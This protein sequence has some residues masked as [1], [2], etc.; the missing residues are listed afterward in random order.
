MKVLL[1]FSTDRFHDRFG[2]QGIKAAAA[3]IVSASSLR[4]V[5]HVLRKLFWMTLTLFFM[6]Y[7]DPAAEGVRK[8]E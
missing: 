6:S 1:F 4:H 2:D 8:I 3:A 7:S 5:K